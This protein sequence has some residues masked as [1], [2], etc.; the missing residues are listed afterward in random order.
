MRSLRALPLIAALLFA[1]SC[2]RQPT[3]ASNDTAS[4]DA[5]DPALLTFNSTFGLPAGPFMPMGASGMMGSTGPGAPF[6]ADLKLTDAQKAQIGTLVAAFAVTKQADIAKLTQLHAAAKAAHD[7]GKTGKDLQPYIDDAKATAE[8]LKAALDALHA[9]IF[10][11]LTPAQQAWVSAHK[12]T[13][14]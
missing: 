4:I 2:E 8:S 11:I 7:A 1:A 3:Q 12:P 13:G 5:I 14:P 9:A 10:N 6:P